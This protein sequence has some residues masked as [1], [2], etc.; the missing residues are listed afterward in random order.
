MG[1]VVP[2]ATSAAISGSGRAA[3]APAALSG[4]TATAQRARTARVRQTQ[5]CLSSGRIGELLERRQ[6]AVPIRSETDLQLSLDALPKRHCLGQQCTTVGRDPDVPGAV[7]RLRPDRHETAPRER[8]K[9]AAETGTLERERIRQL[10]NREGGGD[11]LEA[12]P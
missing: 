4:A 5:R 2:T 11:G 1:A 12:R 7:L 9:V 6:C 8:V 10:G 3:N